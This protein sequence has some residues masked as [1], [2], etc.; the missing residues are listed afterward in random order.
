[1]ILCFM[2]IIILSV[3]AI[4]VGHQIVKYVKAN[5]IDTNATKNMLRES[6]K[7]YEDIAQAINLSNQQKYVPNKKGNKVRLNK[8]NGDVIGSKC[9]TLY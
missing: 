8:S 4:V 7:M 6:K 9:T 3:I 1:M 2:K 5:Y